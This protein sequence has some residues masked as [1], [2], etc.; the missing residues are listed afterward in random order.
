[1]TFCDVVGTQFGMC[2]EMLSFVVLVLNP[3]QLHTFNSLRPR[4]YGCQFADVIFKCIFLNENVWISI[5]ISFK[6]VPKGPIN[7]IPYLVKI[8]AWRRL[9]DK[10]LSAPIMVSLLMYICIT[11]PQ[12]VNANDIFKCIFMGENTW[13]N[14]HLHLSLIITLHGSLLQTD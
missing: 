7:S 11:Q 9:G 8:M 13:I 5:L 14:F 1:M 3:A 6:L 4:Q 12:W 2:E 10:P